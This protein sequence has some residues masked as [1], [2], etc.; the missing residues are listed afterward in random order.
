MRNE[1]GLHL[2][3]RKPVLVHTSLNICPNEMLNIVNY[4]RVSN[5]ESH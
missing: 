2:H 5:S 4:Y 1:T 3:G